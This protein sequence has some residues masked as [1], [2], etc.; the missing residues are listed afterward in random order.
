MLT[1]RRRQALTALYNLA[2]GVGGRA[3]QREEGA[4][5]PVP[6]GSGQWTGAGGLL[7]GF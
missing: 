4:G 5:H 3:R 1:C 2:A 6:A 7:L